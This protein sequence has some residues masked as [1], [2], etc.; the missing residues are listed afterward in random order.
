MAGIQY[1]LR[2]DADGRAAI[3]E[4]S[5]VE[6]SLEGIEKRGADATSGIER[7]VKGF[8]GL[9]AIRTV[10]NE[11]KSVIEYFGSMT[12]QAHKAGVDV[13]RWQAWVYAAKQS[14]ESADTVAVSARYVKQAQADAAEAVKSRKSTDATRAFEAMGMDPSVASKQETGALLEDIA[15]KL[16]TLDKNTQTSVAQTMFGRN[17]DSMVSVINDGFMANVD[18]ARS[19]GLVATESVAN[20]MDK[21]GDMAETA[22]L[23]A[24]VMEANSIDYMTR[25][26]KTGWMSGMGSMGM[27][28]TVAVQNMTPVEV[29]SK[30]IKDLKTTI[31]KTN[32]LLEEKL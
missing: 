28:G 12:D 7:F 24:R 22:R 9:Y 27:E 26:G 29:T 30:D 4:A 19:S 5:K 20:Q 8:F 32:S 17:W 31:E 2:I 11:I 23:K 10:L 3:S 16:P 25:S 14:G 21:L 6:R 1:I 18:K 13:E 15:R